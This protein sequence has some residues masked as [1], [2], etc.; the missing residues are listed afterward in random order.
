[1]GCWLKE[2]ADG[3]VRQ[4]QKWGNLI[5]ET[6]TSRAWKADYVYIN[7]WP[8]AK[9][10]KYAESEPDK[11]GGGGGGLL[12][13][14][15]YY[16]HND[17]LGTPQALT[18]SGKLIWW[19]GHYYP[20]GTLYDETVVIDNNLRFP[21]Q[22]ADEETNLY[23]NWH[24]YYSPD[25]GRYYEADPIGLAGGVNLYSYA[26]NNSLSLFDPT[27]LTIW[28]CKQTEKIIRQVGQQYLYQAFVHHMGGGIYD[29]KKNLPND[30][31]N[32][33]CKLLRADEFGNYLAGYVGYKTGGRFGYLGVRAG[34]LFYDFVEAIFGQ[35]RRP[36]GDA[37]FDFDADSIEMIDAGS[38]RA[39]LE[40]MGLKVTK[41]PC[42]PCP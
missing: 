7:G 15:P 9:I 23:Y 38:K 42:P 40:E 26:K 6:D 25:L 24:R 17:H 27:G 36:R 28:S 37:K 18:H 5:C 35:T 29:F 14:D 13:R 10:I 41:C 1:M 12:M 32:V 19:K 8:V 39:W 20:F 4:P 2:L 34:G 31:F 22:Y 11:G 30:T 21:G 16:Y 33:E 3:D